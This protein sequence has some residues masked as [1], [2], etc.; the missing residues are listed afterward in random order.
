MNRL[1]NITGINLVDPCGMY[2]AIKSFPN[3]IRKAVR[4]GNEINVNSSDYKDIKNIVLCGMGGSAIGGDLARSLLQGDMTASMQICRN[5]N[6]PGYTGPDTLAIGSSYSG[7]TEETL[8]AFKQAQKKECRL[9]VLTTGGQL[10][11]IAERGRIPLAVLPGGLK[12]RA[13]L[14]YSFVPLMLFFNRIGLSFRDADSFESL[15]DF[16]EKRLDSFALETDSDKNRA[17]QLA[18]R[19]YGRIPIIYSGPELTDA[20]GTR[21]KGQICENA[22]MLAFANQFPEFNHNELVGWQIINSMRDYLR[23]IILRDR[24]DHPRVAARMDIVRKMIEKQGVD[25]IE[26]NSEGENRLERIFSL[27]QLGDF[28]SLYLALL[29]KVDPTLAEPIEMLKRELAG[30]E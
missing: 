21:I 12:P 20:V 8:S 23:V 28:V 15:A 10:K 17:K 4:I 16:L 26:I 5:Y 18:M 13:A 1:D 25:V 9:F 6:L 19:L 2:D 30:L 24:D 11:E 3:Q 29:N 22:E 7:D 14:G 27:I